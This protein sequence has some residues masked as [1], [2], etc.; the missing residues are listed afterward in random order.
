MDFRARLKGTGG[1]TRAEEQDAFRGGE[2]SLALYVGMI[3]EFTDLRQPLTK[4]VL[5][6]KNWQPVKS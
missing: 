1:L 6:N 3:N 4:D 2:T 5:A